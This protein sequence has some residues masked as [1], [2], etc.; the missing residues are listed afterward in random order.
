[1]ELSGETVVAAAPRQIST[2]LDDE[3][4][5]LEL[6]EGVYYGLQG[7]G[8]RV[9]QLVREPVSVNDIVRTVVDEYEVEEDRCRSD[10][11]VFLD[12]LQEAGLVRVIDAQSS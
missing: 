12:E 7:V 9:W 1:M 4:I 6:D 10:V 5:V 8:P 3:T 2:D 11:I